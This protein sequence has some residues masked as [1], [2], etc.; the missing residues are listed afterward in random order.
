[1][2]RAALLELIAA[3][4]CRRVEIDASDVTFIDARGLRLLLT[5]RTRAA[6]RGTSLAMTVPSAAVT[7][8]LNL[9][10]L[11]HAFDPSIV[12]AR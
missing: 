6:E 9:C 11:D 10:G 2:L 3:S 8:A 12:P 4:G 1:V 7:R 5:A